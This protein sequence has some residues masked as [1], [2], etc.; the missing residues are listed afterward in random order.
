MHNGMVKIVGWIFL[1]VLFSGAR[2]GYAGALKDD[3][4]FVSFSACDA[5]ISELKR[6]L[7]DCRSKKNRLEKESDKLAEKIMKKKQKSQGEGSR[8]LDALLRGSQQLVAD[9]ESVSRQI[10]DIENHLTRKYAEAIAS[11]VTQLE[12]GPK[13]KEKNAYMK[14]LLAYIDASENLEKPIQFQIPNVDLE[15]HAHDT[16]IEIRQKADF[17]SDR[18]ALLKAKM[19]Q[20][21]ALIAKLEQEKVLREKIKKFADEI[22]FFDDTHFIEE[23]KV[24]KSE[25]DPQ[26]DQQDIPGVDNTEPP[27][28]QPVPPPPFD[29]SESPTFG[30]ISPLIFSPPFSSLKEVSD[31]SPSNL[32]FSGES[33]DNQISHLKQQKSRLENHLLQL[34]QKTQSFYKRAEELD[35]LKFR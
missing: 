15:I 11:L 1:L 29:E 14:K 12:R 25:F 9:L 19:Y 21:N 13:D 33:I 16:P 2:I 30:E 17:L 27:D 20:M 23:R 3:T 31:F 22:S 4:D 26:K 5:E 34:W 6:T 28:E 32:I 18:T 7:T 8:K 10:I 24:A 35:S